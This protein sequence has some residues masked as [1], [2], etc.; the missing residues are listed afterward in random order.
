[1]FSSE[2][3]TWSLSIAEATAAECGTRA[4]HRGRGHYQMTPRSE[5]PSR[6]KSYEVWSKRRRA[7][8]TTELTRVRWTGARTVA[9]TVLLA[10]ALWEG[11]KLTATHHLFHYQ[12]FI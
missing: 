12:Y 1:M 4:P 7:A 3:N 11:P 2:E 10:H 9:S 8:A 5:I 6:R